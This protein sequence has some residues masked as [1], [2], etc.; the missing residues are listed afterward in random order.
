MTTPTQL[1]EAIAL[2]RGYEKADGIYLEAD[3][4]I[5]LWWQPPPYQG[6]P[7]VTLPDFCGEWEHAGVLL[8]ELVDARY[9]AADIQSPVAGESWLLYME[10]EGETLFNISGRG[11]TLTEAISRAWL[12]WKKEEGHE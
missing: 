3:S 8:E 6:F 7:P 1:N 11:P 10:E 5:E 12:A 9:W 4:S 2:E